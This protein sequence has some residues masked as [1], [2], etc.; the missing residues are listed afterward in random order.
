MHRISLGLH[1]SRRQAADKGGSNY[2]CPY[3]L[4]PSATPSMVYLCIGL[5]VIKSIQRIETRD[6]YE[7]GG[8]TGYEF[9]CSVRDLLCSMY[10]R[11]ENRRLPIFLGTSGHPRL[12]TL[13]HALEKLLFV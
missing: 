10:N 1:L 11:H 12:G 9:T 8:K 7:G 3:H 2:P 4:S 5:G 6:A 13:M